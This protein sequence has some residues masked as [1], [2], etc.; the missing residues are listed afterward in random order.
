M[1]FDKILDLTSLVGPLCPSCHHPSHRGAGIHWLQ[2]RTSAC[3]ILKCQRAICD[4]QIHT[5]Q[6]IPWNK[7][8]ENLSTSLIFVALSE[9]C[10][11]TFE[12]WTANRV[13]LNMRS[14]HDFF[15]W[16]LSSVWYSKTT[17]PKQFWSRLRDRSQRQ[18]QRC[19]TVQMRSLHNPSFAT[20]KLD[21]PAPE[22]VH[23]I[24]F[25]KSWRT[26]CARC[27]VKCCHLQYRDFEL[28][29]SPPNFCLSPL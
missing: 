23:V 12:C 21:L 8:M 13:K 24:K 14:F 27:Y 1:H 18:W 3:R 4:I 5:R 20:S 7:G 19:K 17:N 29:W 2:L 10:S 22:D 28:L 25:L 16:P 9:Y 15:S 26:E 6:A 11:Q